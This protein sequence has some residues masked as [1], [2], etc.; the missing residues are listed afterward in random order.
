MSIT[1]ETAVAE[2][3]FVLEPAQPLRK[4]SAAEAAS[5]V[6]IDD[7][8]AK[9]IST[10]VDTFVDSIVDLEARSPEFARKVRSISRMGNEEIRR[11]AGASSRF[12][13]RPT[14]TLREGPITQGS[15]VSASLLALRKQ[16]EGLDPA[17]HL[18]RRRGLFN[19][20]P[21]NNQVTEYFRKYQSAQA[22]IEGIIEGLYKGQ[23]ELIRDNAAIE[24]ENEHLWAMKGRLEQFVYMAGALDDAV[25]KK[26]ADVEGQDPEKARALRD[27]ALFYVRQKRQDLLTQLAVSVQ[28]YIAL[29]LIR[30]N[31]VELIKGVERA[32]TT[33]VSALRTA[34]IAALA[35]G[36]QR[37]VLNQIT[38]LNDTTGTIIESTAQMLRQQV[39]EIQTQAVSTTVSLEKLQSAF[40]N[41]YATIDLIDTF[42]LAALDSMRKTVDTLS[43]EV[44]KANVYMERARTADAT[45]IGTENLSNELSLP[46]S[47]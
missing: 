3:D 14:E 17:Q 36:N 43:T 2:T 32:T 21:F 1:P 47:K 25:T 34:V 15:Q 11:A 18:G 45:Q 30:K 44:A 16:I 28:G 31:N 27:D 9:Q 6:R 38:A 24:K 20:I 23:D 7:Q 12:L 46:S 10:M 42:K 40:N 29:D 4:V 19:R 35:L 39:G 8:T 37:L 13:D 5:T 22:N 41:I 33:T 26:I